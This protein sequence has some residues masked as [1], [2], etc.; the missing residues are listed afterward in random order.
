MK[1]HVL[2]ILFIFLI[3]LFSLFN[4][5]YKVIG[6]NTYSYDE[7]NYDVYGSVCPI[8][9]FSPH[10]IRYSRYKV[11]SIPDY[12]YQDIY[13]F[14]ICGQ[15]CYVYKNYQL[16]WQFS[17]PWT[18]RNTAVAYF[19]NSIAVV[20]SVDRLVFVNFRTK[21][22]I[23]YETLNGVH[24]GGVFFVD[25]PVSTNNQPYLYVMSGYNDNWGI[26]WNFYRINNDLT[27]TQVGSY[28]PNAPWQT[29]HP[30]VRLVGTRFYGFTYKWDTLCV[31]VYDYATEQGGYVT[32]DSSYWVC[33]QQYG[34]IFLNI[35]HVVFDYIVNDGFKISIYLAGYTKMY[36]E[37]SYNFDGKKVSITIQH[38]ENLQFTSTQFQVEPLWVAFSNYHYCGALFTAPQN[39]AIILNSGEPYYSLSIINYNVATRSFVN[40]TSFNLMAIKTPYYTPCT[41]GYNWVVEYY[42]INNVPKATVYYSSEGGI[43]PT[44]TYTT[45]TTGATTTWWPTVTTTQ[46]TSQFNPYIGV[47]WNMGVIVPLIIMLFPALLLGGLFGLWGGIVGLVLGLGL[48]VYAGFLPNYLIVLLVIAIGCM[49]FFG[50]GIR[51]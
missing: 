14:V 43:I 38:N 32:F 36:G 31:F 50:R 30:H 22:I 3:L 9:D 5:Q 10:T 8:F 24:F 35:F 29:V 33:G 46:P 39:L 21:T 51:K 16:Y 48:G 13:D 47:G 19:N 18:W 2:T 27:V 12:E 15:T 23:K 37:S 20:S 25:Y 4:Q 41:C 6:Y 28:R 49:A 40:H 44:I 34:K 7:E 17:L 45:T 26:R 11:C 1:K 42:F